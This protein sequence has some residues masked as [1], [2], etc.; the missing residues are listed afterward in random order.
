MDMDM[1]THMDME[2]VHLYKVS[3]HIITG[4]AF[5]ADLWDLAG[6]AWWLV[7][8][9]WLANWLLAGWLAGLLAGL[10][11]CWLVDSLPGWLAGWLAD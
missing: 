5:T 2:I 4:F 9:G 11:I 7:W 6:M 10:P 3:F 1:D 8:L